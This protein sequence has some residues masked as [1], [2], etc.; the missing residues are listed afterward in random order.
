[1]RCAPSSKRG[2]ASSPVPLTGKKEEEGKSNL[3]SAGGV[4]ADFAM[5]GSLREIKKENL[6][7]RLGEGRGGDVSFIDGSQSKK[8]K[9]RGDRVV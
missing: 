6:S 8:E 3:Y 5:S 4:E 9:G 1:M 2:H 7:A